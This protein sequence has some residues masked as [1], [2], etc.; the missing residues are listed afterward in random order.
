MPDL[1]QMSDECRRE[2]ETVFEYLQKKYEKI[3]NFDENGFAEIEF[4][5]ASETGHTRHT[6]WIEPHLL[7]RKSHKA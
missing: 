1:S 2:S 3:R 6:V 5:I 4:R 7:K